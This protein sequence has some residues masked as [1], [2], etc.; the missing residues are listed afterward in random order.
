MPRVMTRSASM[1]GE[2]V[3]PLGKVSRPNSSISECCHSTR[4][5]SRER[6]QDALRALHI[7]V[8]RLAINRGARGGVA[9][10]D[11][12]AQVIVVEMLPELLAGLGVEAGHALLQVRPLALRSPSRKA[13][14]SRSRA[15]IAR[16]I[17]P[18]Q[19][20]PAPKR[21]P[22]GRSPANTRSA[23]ARASSAS[24]AA[25]PPP[26]PAAPNRPEHTPSPSESRPTGRTSPTLFVLSSC[27]LN[28]AFHVTKPRRSHRTPWNSASWPMIW[29]M[30]DTYGWAARY[31]RPD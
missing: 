7:D 1:T 31:S 14:R 4:P 6:R 19:A 25:L 10:V 12:I 11:R 22:A 13:C 18:P 5:S 23:P 15:P 17:R 26:R 2:A 3:R 24:R 28:Q 20:C 27:A 16:E 30:E 9:Q 29:Q 8:A 21:G